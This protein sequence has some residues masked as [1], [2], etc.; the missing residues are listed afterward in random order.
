MIAA[1][2]SDTHGSVGRMLEAVRETRPDVL[3]HL[4][5]YDRD[6]EVLRQTFPDTPLYTVCGNCDMAPIAPLADIADLGGVKAYLCHGHQYGVDHGDYSRL[7]YAA[8]ERGC[9]LALFGHTHRADRQEWGGVTLLNP[10]AAGKGY[11]LSWA[12]IEV[13]PNGGFACQIHR[14]D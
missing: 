1:V 11:R 12:T 13:F 4:G 8:Q 2:F 9:R 6:A 3:I 7:A 5:D 10:G 14:F